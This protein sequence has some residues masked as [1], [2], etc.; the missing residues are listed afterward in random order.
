MWIL[1]PVILL[2]VFVFIPSS[3]LVSIYLLKRINGK[4]IMLFIHSLQRPLSIESFKSSIPIFWNTA[5]NF[6]RID[7]FELCTNIYENWKNICVFT[8]IK[9]I[10]VFHRVM[11]RK[12]FQVIGNEYQSKT[13]IFWLTFHFKAF[14]L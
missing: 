11:E 1:V 4:P 2:S 14:L 6:H 3:Y 5:I 10:W 8:K 9:E 13:K 7:I 12:L